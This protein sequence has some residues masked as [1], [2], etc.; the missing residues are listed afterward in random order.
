MHTNS[1]N[2]A[3]FKYDFANL[4]TLYFLLFRLICPWTNLIITNDLILI[5]TKNKKGA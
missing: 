5:K 2:F 4:L 3:L 1:R